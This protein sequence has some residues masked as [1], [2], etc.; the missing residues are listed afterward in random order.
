M[1]AEIFATWL[2][3]QGHHIYHTRSSYWYDAGPRVL[4]AFPYH[5]LIKPEPKELRSLILKHNILA[6]RYSTPLEAGEGMISYHVVLDDLD[7]SLEKLRPQARNGIRRGLE[8]CNVER[9]SFQQ[10]A[11]EGWHLQQDTL[12]RQN[13]LNSMRRAEWESICLSA[14]NLPGFEAW[15]AIADGVLA[16]SILVCRIDDKVYVPFAQSLRDYLPL[17]VNNA[18]FYNASRDILSHPGI[19]G[20]FFSLHSLDAPESVNEFKFR[21]GHCAKPVRQCVLLHPLLAPFANQMAYQA[22]VKR[23]QKYPQ[24]SFTAKVEGM[25]R[26]YRQGK[27]S[28]PAQEW[29][30]CLAER[31]EALLSSL[32]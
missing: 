30:Q 1:N 26:F 17:H 8:K 10:L 4:Q 2:H 24:D 31:K 32:T 18:L 21:M 20:I 28:L 3:R 23:V 22:I 6:L 25:L 14:E 15:G 19:T 12:D 27:Q 7:Y 29:P 16:A 9:I 5:W 11:D 13:R